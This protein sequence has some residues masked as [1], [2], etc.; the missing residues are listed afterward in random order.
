MQILVKNRKK[1]ITSNYNTQATLQPF[2]SIYLHLTHI[3]FLYNILNKLNLKFNDMKHFPDQFKATVSISITKIII[4]QSR[5]S[6]KLFSLG[7]KI[8]LPHKKN[9]V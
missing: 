7:Q 9:E 3:T 5:G 6:E 4:F 8:D 2:F 1:I